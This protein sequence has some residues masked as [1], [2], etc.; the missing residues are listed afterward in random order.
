MRGRYS[1][2]KTVKTSARML[3]SR[4]GVR[5]SRGKSLHCSITSFSIPARHS[6]MSGRKY[7]ASHVWTDF[8]PSHPCLFLPYNPS[9]LQKHSPVSP[10]PMEITHSPGNSIHG[11]ILVGCCQPFRNSH[12]HHPSLTIQTTHSLK[13][14]AT[15]FYF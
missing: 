12:A 9:S 7:P 10:P 6:E 8:L 15:H 2:Q 4:R 1:T 14:K 11:R 5:F 3:H 13:D